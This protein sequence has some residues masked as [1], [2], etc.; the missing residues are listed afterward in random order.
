[1]GLRSMKE[2]AEILGGRVD[3]RSAPGKGT[4]IALTL[5]ARPASAKRP[6]PSP[7]PS[8]AP[9]RPNSQ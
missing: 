2:M 4:T 7:S 3:V 8:P 9:R 6:S 5:P 1:M